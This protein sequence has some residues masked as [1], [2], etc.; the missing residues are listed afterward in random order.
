MRAPG[1]VGASSFPSR[2][3]RGQRMAGRMG[4]KRVKVKNLR[5]MK[6]IPES[7]LIV[8]AGAVPGAINSFVRIEK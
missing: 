5:V 7:H 2:V 4:G 6:V 8:V 3:F 1:S